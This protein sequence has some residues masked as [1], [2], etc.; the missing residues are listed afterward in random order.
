MYINVNRVQINE[1][2]RLKS[3]KSFFVILLGAFVLVFMFSYY[4]IGGEGVNFYPPCIWLSLTDTYC[5]GCGSMRGIQSVIQGNMLGL[6]ENNVFLFVA[7]PF[8]FYSFISLGIQAFK[9]YKP[10]T[11]FLTQNEIYFIVFMI[12]V[13]WIVRNIPAFEI[14][15]PN[16]I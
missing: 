13:F 7:L 1:S 2:E 4:P 14:L 12:V 8:L 9:G 5:P 6:F 10:L 16:S 11:I 3:K 15:A